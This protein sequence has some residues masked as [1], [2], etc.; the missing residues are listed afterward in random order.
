MALRSVPA[1]LNERFPP[2]AY[3]ILVALFFGSAALVSHAVGGGEATSWAGGVVVLLVF[4]HLR[5]FDEHKDFDGDVVAYPDRVLSRGDVTLRDLRV[6]G[7]IAIAV[8]LAI[9]AWIGPRALIAWAATLVFTLLMLKEFF[10]GQWLSKHIVVYAIT[11]N[12][13]VA[14]LALLGWA[15]TDAGWHPAYLAY[16]A[17]ISLASLGFEVG[18]KFRL[19]AE[20]IEGVE[21][22][23]SVLGRGR[24]LLLLWASMVGGV[25]AFAVLLRFLDGGWI[26]RSWPLSGPWA[27]DGLGS[28]VV[29]LV[30]ISPAAL[31][32]HRESA[33]KKVEGASTLVLFLCMLLSGAFAWP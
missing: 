1:Y 16:V 20:E 10:V 9:C 8:E 19:P 27:I 28:V 12:P 29:L 6:L 7:A 21:S 22:Y 30:A 13:V 26:A 23:T 4:F 15:C 14:G 3:S 2:V 25:V 18:R 33:A 5:V 11:H 24:A 17:M 31:L 32:V